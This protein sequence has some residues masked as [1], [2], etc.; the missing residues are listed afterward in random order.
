M[1]EESR[2]EGAD[3]RNSTEIAGF[4]GAGTRFGKAFGYR[5]RSGAG[6]PV[7]I[8]AGWFRPRSFAAPGSEFTV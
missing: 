4:E 1:R 5:K 2:N 3:C 6:P 7:N 8:F